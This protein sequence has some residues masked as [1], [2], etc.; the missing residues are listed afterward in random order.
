MAAFLLAP[1]KKEAINQTFLQETAN[2]GLIS[3]DLKSFFQ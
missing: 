2:T 3:G 1:S